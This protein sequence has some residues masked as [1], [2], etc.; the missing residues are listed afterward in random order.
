MPDPD[1]KVRAQYEAFPYP[2]RDP[3]DEARRLVT[4]SP[5]HPLEIDHYIFAGRRDWSRPF[6]ALVA[7][8]GTG[9]GAVM[10]AQ[11]LAD[12]ACPGE[13]VYLDLSAAARRIAEARARARGLGNIRFLTGSL[14]DAPALGPFDYI[15]CCGVLHH[16]A[17]P[18]AGLAALAAALEEEG[19]IGLMLYGEL[20]RTGVYPV[21]AMLRRLCADAPDGEKLALARRLLRDLPASNWLKRNP[22]LSDHLSSEAG[23]YDLLLH[24]RDRAYRVGEVLDLLAGAGLRLVTFIEPLR[25]E[26]ASYLRDPALRRM[27]AALDPPA[28]AAF[29]EELCG[30]LKNHVLY[31]V[32]ASRADDSVARPDEP[33]TVPVLRDIDGGALAR[34]MPAGG[35]LDAEFGGVPVSFPLPPL[36]AAILARCDGRRSL[37]EIRAALPGRPDWPAFK[38]QFDA[39]YAVMNGVNRL[40]LR[41]PAGGGSR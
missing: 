20:G 18:A 13:V 17:K 11:G 3:K 36:A 14:H 2:A 25:Y 32:K 34:G 30:S 23:L 10:L 24:S 29:A 15:D 5:S 22:L 16:L 39:L 1:D 31:A 8:G 12:R 21:Q 9:D 33:G 28:R 40:L 6:R 35:A 41:C 4:G 7:G 19:G 27:A 26:P 38:A 37:E